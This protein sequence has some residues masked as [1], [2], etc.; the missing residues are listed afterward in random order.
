MG[1]ANFE[2]TSPSNVFSAQ[3]MAEERAVDGMDVL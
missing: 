3:K 2:K 1:S